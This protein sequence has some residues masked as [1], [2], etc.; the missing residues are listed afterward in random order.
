MNEM[1]SPIGTREQ[2]K[3]RGWTQSDLAQRLKTNWK[4]VCRFETRKR[5]ISF[6]MALD[7]VDVFGQLKV[8]RG[9][10]RYLITPD[11]SSPVPPDPKPR[12]K[13]YSCLSTTEKIVRL[14]KELSEAKERADELPRCLLS[15]Q[16]RREHLKRLLKEGL[17]ADMVLEALL[18]SADPALL[19]E[20]AAMSEA[21][22]EAEMGM[23]A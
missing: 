4:V 18:A 17:E 9:G 11:N 6:N 10:K 7:Y 1:I 5:G 8:E 2:R 23:S 3:E 20:A 13:A 22:L 19:S 12:T 14:G 16:A 15:P 21:E